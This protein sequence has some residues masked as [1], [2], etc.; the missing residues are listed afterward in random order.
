M[1]EV[2]KIRPRLRLGVAGQMT[3]LVGNRFEIDQTHR[4]SLGISCEDEER[5]AIEVTASY[6]IAQGLAGLPVEICHV[7]FGATLSEW[8]Y[9]T[10][11]IG[12]GQSFSRE[13]GI[14]RKLI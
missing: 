5:V 13:W 2:F 7:I 10:S 8:F 4:R 1:Q 9:E 14:T 6:R 12:D 11:I 3:F